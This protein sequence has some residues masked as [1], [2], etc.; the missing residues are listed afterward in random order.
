MYENLVSQPA[1]RQ[2]AS[3]IRRGIFPG[4]VLFS[5][6]D[7]SGKLTAALEPYG[8]AVVELH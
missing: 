5:G 8:Y 4:A 6:P 7:A 2:L 1:G 3:D